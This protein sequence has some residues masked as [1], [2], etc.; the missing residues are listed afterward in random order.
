MKVL[1]LANLIARH[2][3]QNN[4][5]KMKFKFAIF[6][7]FFFITF[8]A[9]AAMP[10][11]NSAGILDDI[12]QRFSQ[13]ASAWS[14]KMQTYGQWL[15]WSLVLLSMVW[16]YSMML[17]KKGDAVEALAELVRFFAVTGF[18]YWIMI[19]APAIS[20]SIMTSLRQI[21]ANATGLPNSLS[22]SGIINIGFD[23]AG[24]VIDK[25]SI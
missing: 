4:G 13:T 21:A 11:V 25:S 20:T 1:E 15:F 17:L 12:L 6:I 16:T 7:A 10:T 2:L 14:T 18:F 5:E 8:Y 22:P 19:N 24:K 3:I 23:I 9:N